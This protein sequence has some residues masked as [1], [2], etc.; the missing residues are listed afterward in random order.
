[1]LI[2]RVYCSAKLG[3]KQGFVMFIPELLYSRLSNIAQNY[4][5]CSCVLWNMWLFK[6]ECHVYPRIYSVVRNRA[7]WLNQDKIKTLRVVELNQIVFR[8][9]TQWL[10]WEKQCF[11][12]CFLR[13]TTYGPMEHGFIYHYKFIII[14]HPF[15]GIN[16]LTH[17]HIPSV[18]QHRYGNM[19]NIEYL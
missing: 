14:N 4:M 19:W 13:T 12:P 17:A 3:A 1:M 5:A 16:N 7:T 9:K 18:N 11:D 6:W 10:I 15:L 8:T 2:W